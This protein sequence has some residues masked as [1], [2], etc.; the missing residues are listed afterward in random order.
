MSDEAIDTQDSAS[1]PLHRIAW[2][3]ASVIVIGG[4]AIAWLLGSDFSNGPGRLAIGSVLL[5]AFVIV[6]G[7]LMTTWRLAQRELDER[8]HTERVLR[9]S[10]S[11]F[12]QL[13]ENVREVFYLCEWPSGGLS[14]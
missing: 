3:H 13:A 10:E 14:S 9:E 8:R 2:L 6:A 11:V 12:R 1:D 5:G 4:A 7:L